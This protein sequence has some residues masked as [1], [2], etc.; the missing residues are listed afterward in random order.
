MLKFFFFEVVCC[1]Q[2]YKRFSFQFFTIVNR[3]INRSNVNHN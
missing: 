3:I 1:E 2:K